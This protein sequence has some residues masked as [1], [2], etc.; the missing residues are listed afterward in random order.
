MQLRFLVHFI[1]DASFLVAYLFAL[2]DNLDPAAQVI[3][4]RDDFLDGMLH[5][6]CSGGPLLLCGAVTSRPQ[7]VLA[8]MFLDLFVT[9]HASIHTVVAL[10]AIVDR[11]VIIRIDKFIRPREIER[12]VRVDFIESG[13]YAV[14]VSPADARPLVPIDGLA[15]RL[16]VARV[17]KL[18]VHIH[19]Q[20]HQN[21]DN[22]H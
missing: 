19:Q 8:T 10:K 16:E 4:C 17:A 6:V 7:I 11:K 9:L 14:L 20:L 12:P 18:N 1:P 5:A 21:C 2:G 3:L 15:D 22:V 13:P